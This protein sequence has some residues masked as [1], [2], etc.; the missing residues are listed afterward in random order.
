MASNLLILHPNIGL[1]MACQ[2]N[3]SS[4]KK[5]RD[6]FAYPGII[7]DSQIEIILK[8]FKAVEHID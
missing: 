7:G 4:P 6:F 8:R 3:A 2:L 1:L 5:L